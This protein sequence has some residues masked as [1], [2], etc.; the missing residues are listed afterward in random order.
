MRA[1]TTWTDEV[2][3]IAK[4]LRLDGM[5][6]E[7]IS[8]ELAKRGFSQSFSAIQKKAVADKWQQPSRKELVSEETKA[9]L[10]VLLEEKCRVTTAYKILIEEGHK[11]SEYGAKQV[12]FNLGYVEACQSENIHWTP[13]LDAIVSGSGGH[14]WKASK[15]SHALGFEVGAHTVRQR[16]GFLNRRAEMVAAKTRQ[17]GD[18]NKYRPTCLHTSPEFHRVLHQLAS[19]QAPDYVDWRL[20]DRYITDPVG[21]RRWARGIVQGANS[22]SPD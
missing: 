4:Q 14:S 5:S 8:A 7:G 15:L 20:T 21:T 9:R 2:I 18:P 3:A 19:G 1:K 22:T 12:A 16:K 13:A 17:R 11:I 10:V 6:Y